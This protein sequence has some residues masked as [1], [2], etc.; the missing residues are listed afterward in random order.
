M[1][2]LIVLP[3]SIPL[4]NDGNPTIKG[5]SGL[6]FDGSSFKVQGIITGSNIPP[7]LINLKGNAQPNQL[8]RFVDTT[9]TEL[10]IPLPFYVP[11]NDGNP[12]VEAVTGL[13][14]TG[15]LLTLT[16]ES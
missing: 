4:E 16:G 14:M 5:V 8:V 3:F 9:D 15:D 6:T 2:F 1:G 11:V 12:T 10:P 7:N 13:S